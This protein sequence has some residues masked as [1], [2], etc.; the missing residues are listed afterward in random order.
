M[1]PGQRVPFG[2]EAFIVEGGL[3]ASRRVPSP[4]GDK[5]QQGDDQRLS[6]AFRGGQTVTDHR[7]HEREGQR[8][9]IEDREGGE[10]QE[11]EGEES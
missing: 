4:E 7:D 9:G 1:L 11:E 8:V 10:E 5:E 6:P 3:G 2:E